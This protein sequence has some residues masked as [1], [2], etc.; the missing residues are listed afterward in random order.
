MT[1]RQPLEIFALLVE[2]II[3]VC[4]LSLYGT[5]HARDLRA[6]LWDIG[7][8]HGWNSNPRLRVYFHAN[9]QEPPEIPLVWSPRFSASSLAIAVV[10]TVVCITKATLLYFRVS[11]VSINA[12]YDV[13]LSILWA[14]SASSQL[15]SDLTDP[16][17]LSPR[18]W[19][20]ERSCAAVG[21]DNS[22]DCTFGRLLFAFAITCLMLYLIRLTLIVLGL[23]YRC[24][25]QQVLDEE[26][27]KFFGLWD[28]QDLCNQA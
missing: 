6:T 15:S 27:E 11:F 9:H 8:Q 3:V 10:G 14:Y 25:R 12:L 2:L 17:H 19:Y 18:P 24:G 16:K 28:E 22:C 20:L 21:S 7:G 1:R 13:A 4:T 26:A 5:A 23:A